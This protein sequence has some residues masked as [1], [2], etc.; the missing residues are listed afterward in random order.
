[1]SEHRGESSKLAKVFFQLPADAISDTESLW[2]EP[3]G[4]MRYRLQNIPF[5]LRGYSY[6]DIVVAYPNKEGTLLVR[7]G[8][9]RGGHSTYRIF[10]H[11]KST[12][13]V[14]DHAL[15]KQLHEAG[16]THERATENLYAI[17]V[18]PSADIRLVYEILESGE[19]EGLWD[20]E[21]G[22]CGHALG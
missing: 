9:K 5:Y 20:F 12:T 18:P 1:M 16:C 4:A 11:D 17:D 22:H 10:T 15:W 3:L 8:Y 2:A 14:S 21:E 7:D 13:A 6:D 19:Q